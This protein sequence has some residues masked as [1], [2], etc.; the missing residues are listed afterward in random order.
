ML[1]TILGERRTAIEVDI[2]ALAGGGAIDPIKAALIGEIQEHNVGVSAVYLERFGGDALR[3][4]L[5]HLQSAAR[6]R[7][8]GAAWVRAGSQPA[9]AMADCID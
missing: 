5:D 1:R 3:A 6:P 2:H 4:Y 7:G 8:R 9:A